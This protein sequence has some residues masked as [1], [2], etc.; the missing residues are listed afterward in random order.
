MTGLFKGGGYTPLHS[1]ALGLD[2]PPWMV[3]LPKKSSDSDSGMLRSRRQ[4]DR[5]AGHLPIPSGIFDELE[6]LLVLLPD[7]HPQMAV[8]QNRTISQKAFC[9]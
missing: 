1:S 3:S 4:N 7:H 2:V 5:I 8:L 9:N 6:R